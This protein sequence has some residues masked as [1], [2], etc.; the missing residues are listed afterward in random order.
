MSS[1]FHVL[2]IDDDTVSTEV[3]SSSLSRLG[4]K[5][6]VRETAE[7]GVECLK[8]NSFD[9]VFAALCV[10]KM[11]GRAVAREV[12]KE[13]ESTKFFLITGWKGE[14]EA[15]LLNYDGIHDII[16]KPFNFG[17]IRDKV[18]EHLG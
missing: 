13:S 17:D 5:T 1:C 16:R 4:C 15:S 7:E 14:L 11:G 3:L 18:L 12:K 10:R 6:T 2:I 9:A 8:E